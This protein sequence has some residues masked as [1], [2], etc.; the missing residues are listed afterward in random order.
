MY[1][2]LAKVR[3]ASSISELHYNSEFEK[4]NFTYLVHATTTPSNKCILLLSLSSGATLVAA[5]IGKE[6]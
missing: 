2:L 1:T 4:D 6:V 5:G 3:Y